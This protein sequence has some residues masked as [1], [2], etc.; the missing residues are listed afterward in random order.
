MD[1][2][3]ADIIRSM[4]E[5]RGP[6]YVTIQTADFAEVMAFVAEEQAQSAVKLERQTTMLIRL[7]WAIAILTAALLFFTAVLYK[8]AHAQT[9]RGK[10]AEQSAAK[11]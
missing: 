6:Q 10:I 7:T 5:R 1:A 4:K 11:Q 3:I 2:K 8:D 9:E